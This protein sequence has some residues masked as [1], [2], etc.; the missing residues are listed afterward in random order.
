MSNTFLP[1]FSNVFSLEQYVNLSVTAVTAVTVVAVVAAV[2][3]ATTVTVDFT[4]GCYINLANVVVSFVSAFCTLV[5]A[6]YAAAVAAVI[7]AAAA[8]AATHIKIEVCLLG[9]TARTYANNCS[10]DN[11]N[12]EHSPT[13]VQYP[14]FPL[15]VLHQGIS[16]RYISMHSL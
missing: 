8:A 11:L 4:A 14:H 12:D 1:S 2:A 9:I 16:P 13:V 3:A 5:V 10:T 7:D 6:T 15:S